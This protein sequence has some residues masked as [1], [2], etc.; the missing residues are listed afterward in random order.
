MKRLLVASLV[1]L[2]LAAC[3][4][5]RP[6]HNPYQKPVGKEGRMVE[7]GDRGFTYGY[8][9]GPRMTPTG[10]IKLTPGFGFGMGL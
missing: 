2:S 4:E 3:K 8:H 7:R 10:Q 1:L 6:N 9:I 5:E